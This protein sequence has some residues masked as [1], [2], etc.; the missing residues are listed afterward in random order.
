M[1]KGRRTPSDDGKRA[2]GTAGGSKS[3]NRYTTPTG[4]KDKGSARRREAVSGGP[5]KGGR[6]RNATF[7]VGSQETA[8][9]GITNKPAAEE[10]RQQQKVPPRG[11]AKGE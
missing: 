8:E 7:A 2:A 5:R 6:G 9:Q 1:A 11:Q 3:A 4:K 10:Q